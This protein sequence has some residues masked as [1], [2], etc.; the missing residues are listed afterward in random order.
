[1]SGGDSPVQPSEHVLPA[2]DEA[3]SLR[4]QDQS[5][6][7]GR[8]RRADKVSSSATCHSLYFS[9][10]NCFFSYPALTFTTHYIDLSKLK[11]LKLI[12]EHFVFNF[13]TKQSS[14]KLL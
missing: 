9:V 3:H 10:Q 8:L 5:H 4:Q 6:T 1:M 13:L 12:M 2:G 11:K 7:A 14:S